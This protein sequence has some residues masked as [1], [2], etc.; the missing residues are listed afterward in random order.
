MS[1]QK[2]PET[3]EEWQIHWTEEMDAAETPGYK[4]FVKRGDKVDKKFRGER[5]DEEDVQ[6]LSG[7]TH[8]LN[9]YNSNITMLTCMLYGRTPKVEAARRFAD[10]EDDVSRV[11]GVILTRILN[12]D[13]EVAGE[14]MTSVFRNGLQ[15]RLLPGLGSAR[16]QYQFEEGTE[17]TPAVTMLG[18]EGK[19]IELAPEVQKSVIAD[20]WTDIVY[21]NWKDKRWSPA[22]TYPEITWNAYRSFLTRR[23]FKERF[24]EYEDIDSVSFDSYGPIEKDAENKA[25]RK[26]QAEI[27]EIWDKN[28]RKVFWWTRGA[29][30]ILDE[31]DDI[32]ELE[33]F[34]PEPPP[35]VANV[36]TSQFLPKSDYDIAADLYQSIDDLE[37]RIG[38]LTEAC[39]LVGCYDSSEPGIKRMLNE[40]VEN[41]LIPIQNWAQFKE[42]GGVAGAIEWIPIKEVAEVIQLLTEKQA[43][44]IQQLQQVTGMSD[45]MRGAASARTT[46]VSATQDKLETQ[47]GSIRIEALQNEF[48]RW[49]NDLQSLK[50]EVIAKHYQ[51]ETIKKQSNIMMTADAQYADA[52]IALIKDPD[53]SKWKITVRPETLAIAD[54]AQLKQDRSE[55]LLGLAQFM[56]SAAPLL[57]LSPMALPVLLKLLKW[58]LAGFRGSSEVE[59]ILDQAISQ[60]EK[61][62]PKTDKPD[63]AVEKAKMEAE[64]K[65]K[66][67]EAKMAQNAQIHE[68]KMQQAQQ[69]FTLELETRRAEMQQA[70][71]EFAQQMAMQQQEH[72]LEMRKIMA[73]F[74]AS[75]KEQQAQY[76]FKRKEHEAKMEIQRENKKNGGDQ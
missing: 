66:E 48:A 44:K 29:K 13:I 14:D 2:V 17:T 64:I 15:D 54:Y 70:R 3:A 7:V 58:F 18:P 51:P 67:S 28:T 27:W 19:E 31:K 23:Q 43:Q 5:K 16:V 62:P 45:I 68:Q 61:A 46:R 11:A 37:T 25:G 75:V 57:E 40:G 10:S 41:D 22:R 8:K 65:Q 60:F 71:E 42:K 53:A 73:E 1:E 34:F 36:T 47:F 56:Q 32:L 26:T 35:M 76:E 72:A 69:T 6:E 4:K 63:P 24:K 9:I 59:G 49:V 50:V 38:L 74:V 55:F 30:K 21:T 52:A 20:E 39:K 12:T 33:G